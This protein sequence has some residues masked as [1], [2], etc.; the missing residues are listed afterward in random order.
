MTGINWHSGHIC[1]EHWSC[2]YKENASA[3]FPDVPLPASQLVVLQKKLKQAKAQL[4][5]KATKPAKQKEVVSKG[6]FFW[7]SDVLSFLDLKKDKLQQ[8]EIFRLLKGQG[9]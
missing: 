9:S 6:N 4:E 2:G 7:P 8:K 1:A 3:D 5:R